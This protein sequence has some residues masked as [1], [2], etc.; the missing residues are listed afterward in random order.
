[1]NKQLKFELHS[2]NKHRGSYDFNLLIACCPDL[3]QFVIIKY[4]IQTI[5]FTNPLAVKTLNQ[6][7]LKFFYNLI[8]DLPKNYLCPPI[9]GRADYIHHLADLLSVANKGVI[10]K[11]EGVRILDIGVGANCIYPLL[12]CKE[13]GWSFVGT[14]IDAQSL[15]L[16]NEIISKNQLN[17]LIELRHQKSS[18]SIFKGV[19]KENESFDCTMCNPPFHHS[20]QA[21]RK[22]TEQKWKNLGIKSNGLNFGGQGN[23]LCCPGGEVAFICR[24]IEESVLVKSRWFTTLVSKAE[25][26]PAIYKCLKKMGALEVKTINMS[27][28]QK[29]SRI[30]AWSFGNS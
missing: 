28:G 21:A 19:I 5:N 29:K 11:G 30:V 17:H 4:G 7:L 12:G 2:R 25:N 13:Y 6:A 23:E 26:L 27:Q 10:P 16:A 9:P 1:M 24:M 22:G 14:D 18:L 15:K 3:A 8:W 20:M